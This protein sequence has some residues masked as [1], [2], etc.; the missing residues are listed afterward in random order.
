MFR[1]WWAKLQKMNVAIAKANKNAGD[2]KKVRLFQ[3]HEFIVRLSLMVSAA[4]YSNQGSTLCA[5]GGR[6]MGIKHQEDCFKSIIPPLY[7]RGG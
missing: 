2:T 7:L 1:D 3:D 6:K 4:C 5:A